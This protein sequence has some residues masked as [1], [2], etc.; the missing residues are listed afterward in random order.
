MSK[1][2]SRFDLMGDR[3]KRFEA[4]EG[5]RRCI[6]GLPILARL[7]GRGFSAFTRTLKK[8][9]EPFHAGLSALMQ[10][11]AKY[12][13]RENKATLGYT[14]S[15]EITLAFL[16]PGYDMSTV[17]FDGRMQKL[18]STL[19]A[20][21]VYI[22]NELKSQ[23][24][25][26]KTGKAAKLDCRVWQVPDLAMAAEAFEWR[27]LDAAKNSITMA[28]SAFYSHKELDRKN[29][30]QKHEMLMAKGVN[31]AHYPTHFKRGVF[32][33]KVSV[34]KVLSDTEL[35]RIPPGKRPAGPVIRSE[36][37][38]VEFPRLSTVQNKVETLF[39]G[40]TPTLHSEEA[41]AA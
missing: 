5:A 21:A 27:E 31:W 35:Q 36:V 39:F 33:R 10:E 2:K 32:V 8:Q 37:Q 38:T 12:L 13:V 16:N 11:T 34:E 17:E 23:Y 28:A 9:G 14:Q 40:A 6:P 19:T 7:D 20:D 18:V 25:P 24:V 1:Q 26:E 22:F 15:D 30:T 3:Q 4:A 41:L 29:S